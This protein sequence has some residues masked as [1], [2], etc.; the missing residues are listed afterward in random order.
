MYATMIRMHGGGMM[1][2]GMGT[3][4]GPGDWLGSTLRWSLWSSI[5]AL[6][7]AALAGYW[8]AG[9]IA[10]PVR[11][12]RD[13]AAQLGLR[14][15]SKRVPAEGADEIGELARTFNRMCDRLEAEERS[16]R[17]LLADTAHELR[18]PLA[19][20]QGRLDLLLDGKEEPSLEALMP[21]Q[22][23]VTRMTRLVGD[24]RDLSLAE[25]GQL[26]LRVAKV[27][28]GAQ[29]ASLVANLEPVAEAK[30]IGLTSDMAEDLP[31]IPGDP[32]RIR[33]VI[34]N[35][36][37]NALQYTPAGGNVAVR[38]WAEDG[39]LRLQ[40]SDT[41]PGIDPADLPRIF[42]RFYRGDKSRA[43]ATGGSGLGLAIV[44]S[45]T[46]LHGGRVEVES[47]PGSGTTFVV[48]LPIKP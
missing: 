28:V 14:D 38:A 47:N 22:E 18:H 4:G 1:S 34:L 45:L 37:T 40:V 15:L 48:H 12:L 30:E 21:F 23:E 19:V 31:V 26:S 46:E 6:A 11:Y 13:A 42:D 35:L 10:R 32:D 7:V 17:Q 3:M 39:W 41:G 16:R 36:L 24:L 29:V 2:S 9:R 5:A 44:R 8:T 43:R 33:Q 25:V 20:L 27:D